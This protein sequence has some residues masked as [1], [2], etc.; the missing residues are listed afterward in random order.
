MGPGRRRELEWGEEISLEI[1]K[2]VTPNLAAR[3]MGLVTPR[4][5]RTSSPTCRGV[6]FFIHARERVG[7]GNAQ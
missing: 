4:G 6:Q 3:R 1:K 2:K 7:V 5:S